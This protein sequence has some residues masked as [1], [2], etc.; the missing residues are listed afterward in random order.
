MSSFLNF[1][2]RL[3]KQRD[4]SQSK[5]CDLF[6]EGAYI[7]YET[8]E[9]PLH[10]AA[11]RQIS[12]LK[13]LIILVRELSNVVAD[14]LGTKR[15][16][17]KGMGLPGWTGAIISFTGAAAGA[18]SENSTQPLDINKFSIDTSVNL[19]EGMVAGAGAVGTTN[20]VSS[21]L[22]GEAV[23]PLGGGIIVVAGTWALTGLYSTVID[24]VYGNALK[25]YITGSVYSLRETLPIYDQAILKTSDFYF[26][27]AA[28]WNQIWNRS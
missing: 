3:F 17:I 21:F 19:A 5:A 11:L 6:S 1:S 27:V 14:S 23:D 20:I 25:K 24:N 7:R 4:L 13:C 26:E 8:E 16:N 18:Y 2:F 15:L 22:L 28:K 12:K 10:N 9:N